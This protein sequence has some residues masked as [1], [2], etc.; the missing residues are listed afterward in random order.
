MRSKLILSIGRL[1]NEKNFIH[2]LMAW[3]KIFKKYPDWKLHIVGEGNKKDE[4]MAYIESNEME[5]CCMILPFTNNVH[6]HY[7]EAQI[8]V[9]SS[10][11]EGLPMV[12][13]EAQQYGIPCVSYDCETGPRDIIVDGENGFLVK[14]QQK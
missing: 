3:N 7:S 5:E 12:L 10:L 11:F 13:L 4:M 1:S 9:L 8:F 14:N 6:K 2:L